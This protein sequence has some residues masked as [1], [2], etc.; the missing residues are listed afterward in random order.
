MVEV[1]TT[2]LVAAVEVDVVTVIVE[3]TVGDVAI[4][5]QALLKMEEGYLVRTAGVDNDAAA[6][7]AL[8]AAKEVVTTVVVT[9]GVTVV[10]AVA[11]A[12]GTLYPS[13][14]EQKGWKTAVKDEGE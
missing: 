12:I 6:R 11:E 9:T 14:L 8:A 13:R 2:V 7:F 1:A 5:L 3:V 10:S 4:R